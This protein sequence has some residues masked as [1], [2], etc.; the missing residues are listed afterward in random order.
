MNR[1]FFV[2][3]IS[4]ALL[5]SAAGFVPVFLDAYGL[6]KMALAGLGALILALGMG[7]EDIRASSL[8]RPLAALAA[9]LAISWLFSADP[10]VAWLGVYSQPFHAVALFGIAGIIFAAARSTLDALTAVPVLAALGLISNAALCAL[11]IWSPSDW[12]GG[13]YSGRTIG[14][15]GNPAFLGGFAAVSAPLAISL[16]WRQAR[17]LRWLGWLAAACAAFVIA[18][19]GARGAILAALAGLWSFGWGIRRLEARAWHLAAVVGLLAALGASGAALGRARSDPFRLETY[20][21]AARAWAVHPIVGWGPES[22]PIANRAMKTEAHIHAIRDDSSIQAS[23]HN[24]L[25]QAA[26]TLGLLGLLAYLWLWAELFASARRAL[27]DYSEPEIAGAAGALA[28][29]FVQAKLNPISI[30]TVLMAAAAAGIISANDWIVWGDEIRPRWR[31]LGWLCAFGFA[32]SASVSIGRAVQAETLFVAGN[33]FYARGRFV[34]G[35]ECIRAAQ[36][37]RPTE[38]IYAQHRVNRIMGLM[39]WASREQQRRFS[40]VALRVAG[41]LALARPNDPGS[42]ELLATAQLLAAKHL[43][44][45]SMARASLISSRRAITM[46]PL[47]DYSRENAQIAARVIG[48]AASVEEETRARARI[49]ELIKK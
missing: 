15:I 47:L 24:D 22:F 13:L 31:I 39:R 48:D 7:A 19:S 16:I 26:A 40:G 21:A 17:A 34:E 14:L 45:R 2:V 36:E 30:A 37:L 49:A 32:I 8:W 6:P 38:E 43:N 10:A 20:K 46:D 3:G 35:A 11:Q 29:V 1:F 27:S 18:S 33:G 5:G 41:R 25:L 42:W 44:D 23:A 9:A 28:A 12:W 4:I